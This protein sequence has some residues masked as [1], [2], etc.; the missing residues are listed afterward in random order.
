[1]RRCGSLTQHRGHSGICRELILAGC[2]VDSTDGAGRT[3]LEVAKYGIDAALEDALDGT[4][5]VCPNIA[6]EVSLIFYDD[7]DAEDDSG[8]TIGQSST[9]DRRRKLVKVCL[10]L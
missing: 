4:I 6:A 5:V 8:L 1:M 9:R 7:E 2:S 3:V 10:Q